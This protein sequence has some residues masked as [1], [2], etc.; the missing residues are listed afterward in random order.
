MIIIVKGTFKE[1]TLEKK[2]LEFME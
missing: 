1:I 2:Y